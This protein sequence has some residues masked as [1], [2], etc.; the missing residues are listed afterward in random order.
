MSKDDPIKVVLATVQFTE[1]EMDQLRAGFAPAEFIHR[2][3]K[4]REGI[5]EALQRADVAVLAGDLNDEVLAAPNLKWV[6]CDHAGLNG[7]ARP[8]VFEK[9][10][11]VTGSNGR[12]GPALAQHAFYFALAFT[13]DVREILEMQRQHVWDGIEDFRERPALWGQ[14]LGVLGY[15]HTGQE[16]AKLGKAFGM[17]VIVYRRSDS[18]VGPEVDVALSA[19]AGDN[20]DDLLEQSDV[21]M[22][23]TNL[24]NET[25][26]LIDARALDLMKNTAVLINM[27][28]GPVVEEA[29]LIDALKTG[30]IHGAGLDVFDIEPLPKDSELWDLPNVLITPH[31]TPKMPDKT[32][33]SIDT[34]VENARRFRAG[35]PLLNALS[36]RDLFTP[37]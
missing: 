29:A 1:S 18:P 7:S 4:D 2:S 35:E 36:E 27:A 14:T 37:N 15:G 28:R 24:S 25:H 30:K 26:K 34:M 21:I 10:L 9:G 19:D 11:H 17:R 32:Q 12:S 33:R 16:I 3:P 6:H 8:E 20:L 22:L 13:Y 23:A 5:S 31:A